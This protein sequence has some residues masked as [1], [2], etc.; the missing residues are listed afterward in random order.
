MKLL[1]DD[2]NK[3]KKIVFLMKQKYDDVVREKDKL[4]RDLELMKDQ[5]SRREK[6]AL[7]E[8]NQMKMRIA[9]ESKSAREKL[10]EERNE[11]KKT[12]GA[13][14]LKTSEAIQLSMSLQQAREELNDLIQENEELKSDYARLQEMH[15]ENE[16]ALVDT[17][18]TLKKRHAYELENAKN[19]VELER[20]AH[21]ITKKQFSEYRGA[22]QEK[23]HK[24]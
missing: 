15:S 11:H 13:L 4:K 9:A 12:E 23:F 8:L 21:D 3:V 7:D 2:T 22:M 6:D 19:M 24:K 5:I 14:L 10:E 16:R 18:I 20:G 17:I 1:E